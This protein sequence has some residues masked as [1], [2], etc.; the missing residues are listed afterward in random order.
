VLYVSSSPLFREDSTVVS[1]VENADD[2][3]DCWRRSVS[4]FFEARAEGGEENA[5]PM[6]VSVAVRLPTDGG[7]LSPLSNSVDLTIG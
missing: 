6:M 4:A 3:P 2:L 1:R 5:K 7:Q